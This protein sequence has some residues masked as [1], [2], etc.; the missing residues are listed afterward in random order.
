MKKNASKALIKFEIVEL[1]SKGNFTKA[2]LLA[3]LKN[4]SELSAK[5]TKR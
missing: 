3:I 4:I 2:E 5:T 1:I